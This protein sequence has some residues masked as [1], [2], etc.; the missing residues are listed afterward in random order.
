MG[1]DSQELDFLLRRYQ[2]AYTDYTRSVSSGA[3]YEEIQTKLKVY[4]D[5]YSAY[6]KAVQP[7]IGKVKTP[8][9]APINSGEPAD[10]TAQSSQPEVAGE[11]QGT[12]EPA[13]PAT[14]GESW[15]AK[16][17]AK[18]REFVIGKPGEMPLPEKLLWNIGKALLPAM[19]VMMAA[20]LLAPLS[21]VLMI[22]G[23][24]VVGAGL[25]G[26]MTY[27]YEK[28]MNA[29]YRE[30]PKEDAKIWR[31]VTVQMSVEAVMAP[32]NLATG[33]LFGMVGPTVGSAI[34]R[35]AIAQAGLTFAGSALSSR[36][37]GA[38]KHLW[39]KHYFKYP[40]KIEANEKRIDQI[41]EQH[42]A[43]GTP[44]SEK[45][46][47]ELEKLRKE[48]D[49]MKGEDY[50]NEDFVKDLKRA[51]LSSAISGFAGSIIS[52][53]VYTSSAGR[54]ADRLSM[55]VFGSAA[56]GKQ[57]SSLVS[58]LPINFGGGMAGASLEKSFINEDILELRNEQRRYQVGTVAYQYYDTLI[59]NLETKRDS[60]NEVSAGVDSMV[61]NFAVRAAQLT[62]SGLKHN[63]Y[64]APKTRKKAIED[65]FRAEDPEWKKASELYEDYQTAL[66]KIPNPRQF[67]TPTS[68]AKAQAQ[69]LKNLDS[70]RKA[71]LSQCV[72]AKNSEAQ[73]TKVA[74]KEELTVKY[75]KEV[76]L[77]QVLE[78]GRINGGESHLKAMKQVL[79]ETSPELANVSDND[80]T[81]AAIRAIAKS[82]DDKFLSSTEKVGT[83]EA[84]MKKH[85]DYKAGRITLTDSEAKVLSG[86]RALLSPSQYKAALVEQ[87]VWE[88]KANNVRWDDVKTRM[89]EILAQAERSTMQSY[90]GN[91]G[92]LLGAEMYANGLAKYK[93]NPDGSVSFKEEFH[94]IL[95]R[96]PGMIESGVV[97]DYRTKVNEAIVSSVLPADTKKE[98]EFEDYMKT[99]AKGTISGAS[100]GV[101]DSMYKV[102]KDSILNGFAKP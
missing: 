24:I 41:L 69:Y 32:F 95:G 98:K 89:P 36:I 97:N 86:Q 29:K 76:R 59:R 12:A 77:N 22:A 78:L 100:S 26:L 57:I 83:M 70:S 87:K 54:W 75:D 51:A 47:E 15:F 18:A 16:I 45:E 35:V 73:P 1:Q 7:S 101:V 96:I 58:T 30:T 55:K 68:Y 67:K 3:S 49:T 71:W 56:Q 94:K 52:D 53:K 14:T 2:M 9:T 42:V 6:Q 93:Y 20:A 8:Q 102:S 23:G 11:I 88:L 5:A 17:F 63:L 39:A 62:V 21:P 90:G 37:G 60:I 40:E 66:G 91:W 61:N 13:K 4:F 46:L 19:G 85:E 43:D 65:R 33:G 92:S 84:L 48:I 38:V 28:R 31:D 44:L 80:L 72:T 34:G 10:E 25:G 82:Y 99:F 50:T 27:T 79:K 64:D 74:L 81:R